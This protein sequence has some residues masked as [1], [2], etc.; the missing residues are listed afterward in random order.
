MPIS[1][2]LIQLAF[3]RAWALIKLKSPLDDLKVKLGL[4]TLV[5]IRQNWTLANAVVLKL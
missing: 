5:L 4:R 3:G 1:E 2:I